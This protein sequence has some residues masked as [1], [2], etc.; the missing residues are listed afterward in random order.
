MDPKSTALLFAGQGVLDR[1]AS[2]PFRASAAPATTTS[3]AS[4]SDRRTT[5]LEATIFLA[6]LAGYGR[7][8]CAGIT[9]A[10][11][12]GHGFG[13][14]AALVAAGAFSTAD[15]L[16]IVAARGGALAKSCRERF[17][18]ASIRGP[19][20]HVRTLVDLLR[21][22]GVSLAAENSPTHSVVV[23]PP[24]AITAAIGHRRGDESGV[25]DDAGDARASPIVHGR[26][27]G[28]LR[29]RAQPSAAPS[30]SHTRALTIA[31]QDV[32]RQ[33]RPDRLPRRA[34]G[35]ANQVC[36]CGCAARTGRHQ[37][38]R[39]VR[40]VAR[41]GRKPRL[42]VRHGRGLLPPDVA[43]GD[44]SLNRLSSIVHRRQNKPREATIPQP[45]NLR[46]EERQARV[47]PAREASPRETPPM[48]DPSTSRPSARSRWRRCC[49]QTGCHRC[50]PC[51]AIEGQPN[52]HTPSGRRA[53]DG[54]VDQDQQQPAERG[55]VP[56]HDCLGTNDLSNVGE[57]LLELLRSSAA[58]GWSAAAARDARASSCL[59]SLTSSSAR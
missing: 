58:N 6:S 29:R 34:D 39:R 54:V 12:V 55:F 49:A 25:R 42:R 51:L 16:E 40:S 9:P 8:R 24:A 45:R 19:R 1:A 31:G 20:E 21:A 23:G 38:C 13:E 2:E 47:P 37:P 10:M 14:I 41:T 53:F 46:P 27:R 18:M 32:S 36:R 3:G 59:P 50:R 30:V 26:G 17:S 57:V 56:I 15:G 43:R 11:L 48:M 33:R 7:L 28:R 4:D 52:V 5:S 35:A 22:D 44:T